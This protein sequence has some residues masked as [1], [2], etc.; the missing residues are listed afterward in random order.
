M[1]LIPLFILNADAISELIYGWNSV[2]LGLLSALFGNHNSPL[3]GIVLPIDSR[4]LGMVSRPPFLAPN[5]IPPGQDPYCRELWNKNP[6]WQERASIKNNTD[7][8]GPFIS[9]ISDPVEMSA[10][11]P[12]DLGCIYHLGYAP[13]KIPS[14]LAY[15]RVFYMFGRPIF[16]DLSRFIWGGKLFMEVPCTEGISFFVLIHT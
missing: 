11:T 8:D 14:G 13:K 5:H 1:L 3:G 15:G 6:R 4:I 7:H 2:P 10:L 16:R 12:R 9:L